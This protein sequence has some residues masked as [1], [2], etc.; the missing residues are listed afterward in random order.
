MI[1]V[2][3]RPGGATLRRLAY[4]GIRRPGPVVGEIND[5]IIENR[6]RGP[7]GLSRRRPAPRQAW[8]GSVTID[9]PRR[10]NQTPVLHHLTRRRRR[11]PIPTRVG[12]VAIML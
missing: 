1:R 2:P 5:R 7:V 11:R 10:A 12:E 4:P 6:P 3:S 8:A 9:R